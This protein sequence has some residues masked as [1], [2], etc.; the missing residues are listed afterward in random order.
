MLNLEVQYS[1]VITFIT[2]MHLNYKSGY[3]TPVNEQKKN[4]ICASRIFNLRKHLAI[5]AKLV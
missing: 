2:I 3:W 5:S 4:H 1:N